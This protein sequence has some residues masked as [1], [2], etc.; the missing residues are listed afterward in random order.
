MSWKAILLVLIAFITLS[1]RV[2]AARILERSD[3][4]H[5]RTRLDRELNE[6]QGYLHNNK[7]E[8][9]TFVPHKDSDGKLQDALQDLYSIH[10]GLPQAF[11]PNASG[12]Y[13]G[14]MSVWNQ[15]HTCLLYTSDAADE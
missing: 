10:R 15:S 5:T 1:D 6:L 3:L 12:Y 9:G 2:Y 13:F 7:S 4:F 14:K 11:F 8:Q